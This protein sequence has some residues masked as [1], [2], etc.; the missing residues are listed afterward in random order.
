MC[1]R[2]EPASSALDASPP[3]QAEEDHQAHGPEIADLTGG[4]PD[5]AFCAQYADLKGFTMKTVYDADG[6]MAAY[7]GDGTALLLNERAQI[8]WKASGA[9]VPETADA[10]EAELEAVL[11]ECSHPAACGE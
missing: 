9:S 5:A 1:D 6:A 11:G 7:G 10:L 2:P 8:V 4:P 3:A